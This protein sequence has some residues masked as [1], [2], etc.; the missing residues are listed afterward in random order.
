MVADQTAQDDGIFLDGRTDRPR[1]C[2]GVR[3]VK[4]MLPEI[5]ARL[6]GPRGHHFGKGDS[7]F[8]RGLETHFCF[9]DCCNALSKHRA[10]RSWLDETKIQVKQKI[11]TPERDS[12]TA[13]EAA[14]LWLDR[15]ENAEK[16]VR[17]TLVQ[18]S[19]HVRLHI[20]PLIGH[21]KLSDLAPSDI[22]AFKD[23]LLKKLSRVMARKVLVSFKS[24]LVNARRTGRG[25]PDEI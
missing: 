11:H 5:A 22:E 7:S 21:A 17:S 19:N 6:F 12:L 16:R 4:M 2:A 9:D 10:H 18:Y 14:A 20:G 3:T 13:A 23:A 8:R 25:R 15:V 24:I 1:D